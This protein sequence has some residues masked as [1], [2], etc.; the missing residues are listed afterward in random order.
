MKNENWSWWVGHDEERYHTECDTREEAVRI[1]SEE[2]DG[3]YICEALKP[4]NIELSEFFDAER[5]LEEADDKA[6]DDHGDP[7]G[8]EPLFDISIEDRKELQSAVRDAIKKW[9][10]NNG[11][12]FTGWQFQKMRHEEYIPVAAEIETAE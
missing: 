4:S 1:A 7:E 9:Q 6:Y 3:G 2:Q 5:F 12:V 11:L 8:G 10:D